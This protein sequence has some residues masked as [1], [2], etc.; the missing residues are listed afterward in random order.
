LEKADNTGK[1]LIH[2]STDKGDEV[3]THQVMTRM[4]ERI[5]HIAQ[6]N[7]A[8]SLFG[9]RIGRHTVATFMNNADVDGKTITIQIGHHDIA[10]TRK[11]YMMPK[12]SRCNIPWKN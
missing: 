3:V 4:R 10:L 2:S 12:C 5:N 11:I 1:Y 7:G 9:N 6:E 8:G